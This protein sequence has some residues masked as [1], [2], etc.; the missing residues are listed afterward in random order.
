[1]TI[2]IIL[3]ILLAVSAIINAFF[4]KNRIKVAE[5]E[6]EFESKQIILDKK[7][8]LVSD[9]VNK[10]LRKG[11]IEFPLQLIEGNK[12]TFHVDVHVIELDRY[13]NGKSTIHFIPRSEG[14][15]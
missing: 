2:T 8:K 9:I 14:N 4:I 6:V 5:L 15:R 1:M 13:K 7:I 3:A 11:Y 12:K 10:P